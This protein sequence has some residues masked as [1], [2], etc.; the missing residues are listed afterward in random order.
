MNFTLILPLLA[1][2]LQLPSRGHESQPT[3]ALHAAQ[4]GTGTHGAPASNSALDEPVTRLGE[5][6]IELYD[7][8]ALGLGR[9]GSEGQVILLPAT[10]Q[11]SDVEGSVEY[12]PFD[13]DVIQTL[14]DSLC[15]DE[16]EY[17]G[18]G[19]WE[20]SDGVL[21]VRAPADVQARVAN[22]LA[23][24]SNSMGA[25]VELRVDVLNFPTRVQLD[26]SL[27]GIVTAHAADELRRGTGASGASVQSYTLNM[28]PGDTSTLELLRVHQ[29]VRSFFVEVAQSAFAFDPDVVDR[30]SGTRLALTCSPIRGGLGMSVVLSHG[31]PTGE[32]DKVDLSQEG[33]HSSENSQS[34]V[35]GPRF[36][37]TLAIATRSYAFDTAIP[38]GMALSF[39]ST[40]T[41]AGSQG[42]QVVILQP[43]GDGIRSVY[44]TATAGGDPDLFAVNMDAFAPSRVAFYHNSTLKDI[45]DA[46]P[47]RMGTD[48]PLLVARHGGTNHDAGLEFIRSQRPDLDLG[49][50]SNW[51]V[52]TLDADVA[53]DMRASGM[54]T[55]RLGQV[56]EEI[57]QAAETVQVGLS[58]TRHGEGLSRGVACDVPLRLGSQ[59]S[60]SLGVEGTWVR[61]FDVEIAQGAAASEP[62][63]YLYLDGLVLTLEPRRRP[64]GDLS[65]RLYGL[66]QLMRERSFFELDAPM[67]RGMD[68]ILFD[69]LVIDQT[70]TLKRGQGSVSLGNT[71]GSSPLGGLRLDI[72]VH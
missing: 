10:L 41:V 14:L 59:S 9:R 33:F 71:S 67:F 37:Q 43:Q 13:M 20:F 45:G 65:L 29:M 4:P 63:S 12:E 28:L 68:Q 27:L 52:G 54:A 69:R 53:E 49:Y 47:D 38:T 6:T 40:L 22:M 61:D 44:S 16:F 70:V 32:R 19:M 36:A 60:V 24:L 26:P 25:R 42:T 17:E 66:G 39:Q 15:G 21:A 11:L 62:L 18:R 8:R 48:E 7:I 51:V 55:R 50:T 57:V 56:V 3:P 2:S 23:F 34:Y 1:S 46:Q 72:D 58:F 35:Q 31:D 5:S 30:I 64:D